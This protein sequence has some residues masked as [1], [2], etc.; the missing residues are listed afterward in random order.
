MLIA[1]I[2]RV[3]L[4]TGLKN[5]STVI[6]SLHHTSEMYIINNDSPFTRN[7]V[8]TTTYLMLMRTGIYRQK[9]LATV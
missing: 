9:K 1:Y 6:Y 4:V 2:T 3:T 7:R 8:I 5:F